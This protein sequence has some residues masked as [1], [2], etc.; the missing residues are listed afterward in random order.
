MINKFKYLIVLL[1]ILVD[2]VSKVLVL[3]Y[4]PTIAVNNRSGSFSL[5]YANISY[6]Y[7]ALFAL[8]LFVLIMFLLERPSMDGWGFTL[9]LSGAISNIVDRVRLGA[10]VDF[11][12]S[13][14]WATFNIA[15]SFITIGA[16]IL[17]V[18]LL[19]KASRKSD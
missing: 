2:Q 17:I 7:V 18:E 10:V 1:L 9:I 16:I 8:S 11:I 4:F 12:H 3:K 15:D 19:L 5:S 6:I 13:N 14:F